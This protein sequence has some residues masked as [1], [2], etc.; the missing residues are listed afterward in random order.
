MPRQLMCNWHMRRKYLMEAPE[1][2][3]KI[4]AKKPCVTDVLCS[5]EKNSQ[6]KSVWGIAQGSS[7]SWVAKFMGD[8][9]SECKLSNGWSRSYKEIKLLPPAGEGEVAKLQGDNQHPNL[10]WNFKTHGFLDPSAFPECVK[11]CW[12]P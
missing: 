5:W 6:I 11:S 7:I 4:P 3:K 8:K 10:P 12:A 2:H 9:T 1:S